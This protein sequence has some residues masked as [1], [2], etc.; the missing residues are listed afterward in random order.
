MKK[1]YMLLLALCAFALLLPL[2][3]ASAAS[4]AGKILFVPHD[5]RPVSDQQTADVVRK[6]GYD[7]IVPPQE[8]LGG[9]T[10][11]GDPAKLWNWVEE[12]S[13]GVQAA[14]LSSDSLVYGSLVASR[15]HAYT[16]SQVLERAARFARLRQEN[17]ELRLYVYGS[18]MRTPASGENAGSEEPDYYRTYGSDIFQY[19]AL[20]DQQDSQGLSA[21]EKRQLD[22]LQRR[23]PAAVLQDWM[24]RRERNFAVNQ[25]LMDL[26]RNGTLNYLILGKDDNA[27]LSQTHKESRHLARYGADLGAE[28]F[29]VMTGIDEMGLLL[30]TR[31]VNAQ[32]KALP[33]VYVQYNEG[34]GAATVPSYSDEAIGRSI[35]DAI[36]AAGSLEVRH[37]ETADFVLLVNT[38]PKGETMEANMDENQ[39]SHQKAR[40]A[41]TR[42]FADL[43]SAAVEAGQP[44]GIADIAFANG[45]DNALLR[46]LQ[47]R[48]L[49]FK[50]QAYSGW[51]TATNR[52]GFALG[53]GILA[54]RMTE[55]ARDQLLLQRYLDDWA[56]QANVRTTLMDQFENM[57]Q[58]IYSALGSKH[59]AA[60]ARATDLLRKFAMENLPPFDGLDDLQ[61][62]F[63]WD[64]GFEIDV[65]LGQ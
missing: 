38:N 54:S 10:A 26:V 12:N 1:V 20:L 2:Q 25:A 47:N 56:Y 46:E 27:P 65:Q 59:A 60:A 42:R 7:V 51:N 9:R 39:L 40:Q 61:A 53:T 37:P 44:A 43:V 45:A 23:I 35:H 13:K 6:L 11:P 22:E 57:R 4:S 21:A 31:A 28:R 58:D 49:L 50:L 15:K 19:T 24:G 8:L 36:A 52:T 14:V 16:K 63:P 48:G 34:T 29:Q 32:E 55:D 33:F 5:G 64:R 30:L 18:I 41:A 3:P 17:P 62:D